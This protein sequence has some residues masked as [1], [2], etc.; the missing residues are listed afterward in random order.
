VAT[1]FLTLGQITFANFEIPEKIN[2]GGSQ[3]LAVKQLVGGQRV[4]DAMG[5]ID[6]DISWSGLLFES[7]ASFR[8][9]FL[10]TL[11]VSG[12]PQPLTWGIFNY[13][14]VVKE[15]KAN[16][17]RY[18]QIPYTITVTVI[19]DLNKPLPILFPIGYN[20]AI[21]AMLQDLNDL[22][23]LIA[24]GGVISAMA[25]LS[26]AINAIPSLALASPVDLIP[27]VAAIAVVQTAV[28]SAIGIKNSRIFS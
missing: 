2:F 16:F 11:R 15:F 26:A 20:D 21:L 6:D 8:A 5:R 28:I 27:V 18:Y 10:D 23:A 3:S 4:I 25:V 24:D 1:T 22:A 9:Q 13:L 14:V 7:T 12:S 19:Q 17:E